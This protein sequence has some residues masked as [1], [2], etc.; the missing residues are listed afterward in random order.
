[1]KKIIIAEDEV[2]TAINHKAKA[3]KLGFDVL[4]VVY[5]GKEA[6]E[7]SLALK[8]DIAFLDISMEHRSAGIEAAKSIQQQNKEIKIYFVSA[9]KKSQYADEIKNIDYEDFID[10]LDFSTR[11]EAILDNSAS[12][13]T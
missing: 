8:P 9:Y 2:L 11:L 13:S 12:S 5:S 3:Q 4:A 6:V 1:M 7:K 10:K